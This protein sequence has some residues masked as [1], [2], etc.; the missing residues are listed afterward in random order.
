MS[1]QEFQ[2]ENG[3]FDQPDSILFKYRVTAGCFLVEG[4]SIYFQ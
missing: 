3:S 1:R 2:I 4:W